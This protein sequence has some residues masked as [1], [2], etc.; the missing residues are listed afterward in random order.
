MRWSDGGSTFFDRR[1]RRR[2]CPRP[3]GGV[4]AAI[5]YEAGRARRKETLRLSPL[6]VFALIAALVLL[7]G[8]AGAVIGHGGIRQL[9]E[10]LVGRARPASVTGDGADD[11]ARALPPRRSSRRDVTP[12]PIVPAAGDQRRRRAG[13]RAA[14]EM[15]RRRTPLSGSR[16]AASVL[17]PPP[18][19]PGDGAVLDA[20]VALR[21]D[22]DAARAARYPRS[23][24]CGPS[25]RRVAR[26]SDGSVD[27]G[28]QGRGDEPGVERLV[29]Q[30]RASYPSGRFRPYV[31]EQPKRQ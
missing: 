16:G 8:T 31:E 7:G 18:R 30:Y 29:K 22:H 25:A 23:L 9:L 4:W 28:R 15:E 27:R 17:A 10:H 20:M 1:R 21:R 26:G 6:R 2:R 14:G 11:A 3:S 19:A 13:H 5:E 24:P 12:R